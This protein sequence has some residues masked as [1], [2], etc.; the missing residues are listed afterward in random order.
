MSITKNDVRRWLDAWNSHD[1]ERIAALFADDAVVHQP[2]NPQPLD[3]EGVLRFFGGLF[4]T[5]PDLHFEGLGSVI[6]G[7]EVASWEQATGT[8]TGLFQD[9]STGRTVEPTGKSFDIPAA[10][11]LT[12][13]DA[14]LLKE[15]R[16]Y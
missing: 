12:Y 6:E 1:I 3:K 13:D 10:M 2:Q 11:H 15:V 9:P 8:M 16:I 14:A 4:S 5:Y 7:N